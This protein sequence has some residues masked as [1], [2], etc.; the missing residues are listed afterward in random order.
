MGGR[1]I[2]QPIYAHV[3]FDNAI[4][5]AETQPLLD[6]LRSETGLYRAMLEKQDRPAL[7]PEPAAPDAAEWQ[8]ATG[9]QTVT[10]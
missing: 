8:T 2:L 10:E 9:W 5:A 3:E 1:I 7:L 6:F 4:P